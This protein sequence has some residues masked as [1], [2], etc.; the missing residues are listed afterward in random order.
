MK[1]FVDSKMFIVPDVDDGIL[2]ELGTKAAV[3]AYE[4]VQIKI[5]DDQIVIEDQH[6]NVLAWVDPLEGETLWIEEDNA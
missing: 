5:R 1:I 2:D 4:K 6:A 3:F